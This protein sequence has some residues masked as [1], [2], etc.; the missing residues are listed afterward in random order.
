MGIGYL[1]QIVIGRFCQLVYYV[2]AHVF[3]LIVIVIVTLSI[4]ATQK[5]TKHRY[6][7]NI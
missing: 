4:H 3:V 6:A 5:T 1:S 7:T 2:V